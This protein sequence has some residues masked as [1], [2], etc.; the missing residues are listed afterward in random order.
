MHLFG[1]PLQGTN[2]TRTKYWAGSGARGYS[3]RDSDPLTGPP[4][5]LEDYAI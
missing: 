1:T 3:L 5:H 4:K 2:A